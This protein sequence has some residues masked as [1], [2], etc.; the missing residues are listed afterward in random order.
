MTISLLYPVNHPKPAT[1]RLVQAVEDLGLGTL[2]AALDI[3]GKHGRA[4]S[5]ALTVF[6]SDASVIAYRQAILADLLDMPALAQGFGQV[7]PQLERLAGFARGL[8]WGEL[9]PLI[10]I[11]NR[12]AEL[13]QYVNCIEGL[14][15]ILE[16]HQ[17]NAEGLQALRSLVEATRQEAA[18]QSLVENLPQLRFQLEQAGSITIGINLDDQFRPEAA[19]LLSINPSKFSSKGAC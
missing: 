10:Q 1:P 3:D 19:T 6:N 14:W 5:D 11:S 7:L 4:V 8:Q 18:Y 17:L 9:N 12:V 16:N 15:Q 13:E 2:M